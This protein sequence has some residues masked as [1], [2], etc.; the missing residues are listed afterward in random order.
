MSM[1]VHIRSHWTNCQGAVA[2]R[3]CFV[4]TTPGG[5]LESL[6][7]ELGKAGKPVVLGL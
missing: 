6:A 7:N 1:N 4:Y 3:V 5:T 2:D